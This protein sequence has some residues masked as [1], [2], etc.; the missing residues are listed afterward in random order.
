MKHTVSWAPDI[1][2]RVDIGVGTEQNCRLGLSTE[3][4]KCS[5]LYWASDARDV[6]SNIELHC[7]AKM[8]KI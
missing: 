5:T 6:I 8:F 2:D 3:L 4:I 1:T 7:Q